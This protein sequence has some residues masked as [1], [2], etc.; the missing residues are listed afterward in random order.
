MYPLPTLR[1]PNEPAH[2]K[3]AVVRHGSGVV[4]KDVCHE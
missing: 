2:E 1:G 3:E 4:R